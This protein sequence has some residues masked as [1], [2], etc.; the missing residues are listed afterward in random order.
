[1]IAKMKKKPEWV[2]P[3]KADVDAYIKG[4]MSGKIVTGRLV[5]LAVQRHVEDLKHAGERG[6]EFKQGPA[7]DAI[8]FAAICRHSKGEW[9]GQVLVLE[10]WQKF[11]VWCIF[12]WRRKRDGMRR[13][14]KAYLSMG[15]KNAKSTTC[16][17]LALLLFAMDSPIEA[18]AEIYVAATKEAQACIIHSEAARMVKQSPSLKSIISAH[19]NN[20]SI[21]SNDSFFRPL[22]SDSDKTDGLNPHGVFKD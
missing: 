2:S 16:S 14:R 5:R 9:A 20:L 10:P 19:K 15:R 12:G 11:V 8:E 21:Q 17:Y 4:V 7:H 18:G 3:H 1:M 22:G 6:F 13:F